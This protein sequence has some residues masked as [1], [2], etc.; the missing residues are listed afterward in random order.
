MMTTFRIVSAITVLILLLGTTS[1]GTHARSSDD[2]AMEKRF[3]GTWRLVSWARHFTDG[4]TR[5]SP[6]SV[7][8]IIYTDT[9]P[10]HMCFV[11]MDPNRPKWQSEWMPTQSEALSGITGS[12]SYCSTVEVHA[13]AGF[14]IHHVEISSVPNVTGRNRKRW[15][16]FDGPNRVTNPQNSNREL[17][18]AR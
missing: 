17:R 3:I 14:V 4:T 11:G 7:G 18:T 12:N 13:K 9:H 10:V 16:T 2:A 6:Q 15:F 8:Y 5:Q 1:C